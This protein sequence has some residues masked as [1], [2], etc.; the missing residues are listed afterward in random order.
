MPRTLS[1]PE[2]EAIKAKILEAAPAGLK[3]DDFNRYIGPALAGAI[4]EAENSAEPITG[5]A[6]ERFVSGA[7]K[8]LNPMGLVSAVV[9]PIDTAGALVGAHLSQADKARQAFKEGRYSEAL[10]HAV[11]TALPIVGPAAA[12]AGERIGA[13]DM[14]GG[15]GEAAG[16]VGAMESPRIIT[17]AARSAPVVADAV[18]VPVGNAVAAVGRGTE[19]VG[20]SAPMRRLG[21]YGAL[22]LAYKGE[23]PSAVMAASTPYLVERGGQVMQRAGEAMA[24]TKGATEAAAGLSDQV[25]A[26]LKKQGLSDAA[27]EK[28]ERQMQGPKA[29]PTA[30]KSVAQSINEVA[31]V[32]KTEKVKVT[33]AE[34]IEASKLVSQGMSPDQALAIVI[35]K[36][37]LPTNAEVAAVV[38]AKNSRTR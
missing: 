24:R 16:L 35:F 4:G 8:N 10:G 32:A 36:R 34:H 33:L 5:S 28:F 3:E 17:G 26:Q 20:K 6:V 7:W 29:V 9:H 11:A 12:N 18:R 21:T 22:G 30:Q 27:I 37:G 25:R 13:G 23:I 2:F 38:A 15:V 14:A 1:E 31:E 19:A